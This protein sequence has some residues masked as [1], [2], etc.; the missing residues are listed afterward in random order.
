M[1]I[2]GCNCCCIGSNICDVIDEICCGCYGY[3]MRVNVCW[4]YFVVV[5][6][7]GSINEKVVEEDEVGRVS[8][9]IDIFS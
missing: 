8:D 4:I 9:E 6:E 2:D 3:I 7:G 5:D 1:L